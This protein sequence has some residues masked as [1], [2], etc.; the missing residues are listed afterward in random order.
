MQETQKMIGRKLDI[1]GMDACLMNMAEVSYQVKNSVLYTV[2]SEETEPVDGWPYDTIL[3]ALSKQPD[4]SPIELSKLIVKYYINSYK[5]SGE[6]VTQSACDLSAS[7]TV[8][9]AVKKLAS[10][11]KTCLKN[12]TTRA[13][14][15][16]APQSCA[17]I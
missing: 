5:G 1:L 4:M 11:L 14:L 16:D 13:I 6:A 8:A 9:S 7:L 10:A 15:S 17:G 2:G 12:G 3:T